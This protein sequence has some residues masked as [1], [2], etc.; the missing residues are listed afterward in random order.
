MDA[1]RRADG[2]GVDA[3]LEGADLVGPHA[4]GVDDDSG[5][6]VEAPSVGV[7]GGPIDLA[8]GVLGEGDDPAAV[9]HGGA[10][11]SSGAGDREHQPGVVGGGVVVQVA[12]GE[13]VAGDGREVG[14]GGVGLEPLVQPADAEAA[15]EVVHPHRR[16]ERPGDPARD[17]A[18]PGQDRDQERQ[19]LDEVRRVAAQPLA[20][21]ERLVDEADIALLEVAQPPVDELGALRRRAAGE[22]L[23]LDEGGAQAAGGGVEGDPD[24]GDAAA[25]D[26]HVERLAR[27]AL[28]HRRP[29]ERRDGRVLGRHRCEC[30]S[31][32][33]P[34]PR[35]R[36]IAT[37][38]SGAR[39]SP[40][41]SFRST[42]DLD[43]GFLR[44]VP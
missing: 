10:V 26:E 24:A 20:L 40:V 42:T 44:V 9:G 37:I 18:V 4:G 25:D 22:V 5:A 33:D 8:G 29:G 34:S 2:V 36:A 41:L 17:D 16:A 1:L 43:G 7:D 31:D 13:A 27:Q 14:E 32:T 28:E 19:E 23:G 11:D 21:V 30:T 38:A 3:V 39:R 35:A 12:A 6:D 15:G